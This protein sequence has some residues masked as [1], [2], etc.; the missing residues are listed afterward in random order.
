[1]SDPTQEYE[2]LLA[3]WQQL[4][5]E[6]GPTVEWASALERLVMASQ[7]ATQVLLARSSELPS[8]I[9]A[10]QDDHY[11]PASTLAAALAECDDDASFM[12]AVRRW[13]NWEQVRLIWQEILTEPSLPQRLDQITQVA[14]AA[15]LAATEFATQQLVTRFGA[16]EPCPH[17]GAPQRLVILGMGKLGAR[18]L[19]L[20]SDIDLIFA[21]P[22]EGETQGERSL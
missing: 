5:T 14:D 1:M 4:P 8:L 11:D 21:Y 3:L 18:E 13:R 19:N 6:A 12:T 10:L 16:P 22:E 15:L 9:T 7:F 17:S 2:A 20:S